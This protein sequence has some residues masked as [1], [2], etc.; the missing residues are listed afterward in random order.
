MTI[1][2]DKM[3]FGGKSLGKIEGKNV[4][5]PYTIPGENIEING[6]TM[7]LNV[8][9]IASDYDAKR[10]GEIAFNEM[11]KIA[12]KTGTVGLSRR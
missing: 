1:I 6:V 9:A 11:V 5:V 4:F 3:V 10:A 7:N 2:T 12:R 8:P